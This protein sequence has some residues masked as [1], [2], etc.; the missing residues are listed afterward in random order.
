M[1]LKKSFHIPTTWNMDNEAREVDCNLMILTWSQLKYKN[2]Y[3]IVYFR[4]VFFLDLIILKF[5]GRKWIFF[6]FFSYNF[7]ISKLTFPQLFILKTKFTNSQLLVD[8][9]SKFDY[10]IVNNIQ[11]TVNNY[12]QII[13][14]LKELYVF[15]FFYNQ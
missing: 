7:F 9:D 8:I 3:M 4:E 5:H 15:T 14:I 13:K 11:L 6:G 1:S 2:F 10:Y 12:Y